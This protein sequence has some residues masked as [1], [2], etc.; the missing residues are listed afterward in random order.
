MTLPVSMYT[1]CSLIMLHKQYA[2]PVQQAAV[3]IKLTKYVQK[4]EKLLTA[5]SNAVLKQKIIFMTITRCLS[6]YITLHLHLT[7]NHN[8]STEIIFKK[9]KCQ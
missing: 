4:Q 1:L 7:K 2:N 9:Q 8:K 6:R 3:T 5:S